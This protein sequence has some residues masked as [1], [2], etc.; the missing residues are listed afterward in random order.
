MKTLKKDITSL[1]FINEYIFFERQM[2]NSF[3]TNSAKNMREG[4]LKKSFIYL[5]IDPRISENF[6]AQSQ[7]YQYGEICTN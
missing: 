7:V 6:L 2:I 5:L 4:N 1:D 3:Q